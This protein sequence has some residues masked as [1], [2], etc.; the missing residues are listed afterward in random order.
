MAI[1]VTI[2]V[3]IADDSML[4]RKTLRKALPPSWDIEL[5]E[6]CNGREALAAVNAGK[7]DVLFLDL[8]MPELDGF[9]V[10]REL[11]QHHAKTVVI[12]ISA[13]IQPEAQKLVAALG[14]YRFLRKPLQADQLHQT[15]T[16]LG[17]I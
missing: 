5:T 1:P 6:A 14:A 10:L 9:G 7:A 15:L 8:T 16:E 2:P 13:D 4:S 12:V 3:T 11:Q 17:L